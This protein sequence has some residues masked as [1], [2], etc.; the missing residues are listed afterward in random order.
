MS[1]MKPEI[2]ATFLD[3]NKDELREKLKKLGAKL[4]VPERKMKRVVFDQGEHAFARVRDEGDKIVATYKR[5]DEKSITGAK[6]VNVVVDDYENAVLFLKEC[7]LYA[8]KYEESLRESW[9]LDGVEVDIDTWPWLP[10]YVEVE[11]PTVEKTEK[12]SKLLGFDMRDA[13]YGAVDDI[14]E[15]YYDGVTAKDVRYWPRIVFEEKPEGLK[16]KK[17]V[18]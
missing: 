14:Y 9:T 16:G 12:V 17:R 2:E 13:Q 3:I 10:T 15:M 7:G 1:N 18:R 6:E 5:Y 11:G 4:L 8:K